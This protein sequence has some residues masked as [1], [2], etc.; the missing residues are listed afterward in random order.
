ME[1]R[2]V[3]LPMVAVVEIVQI[4]AVFF[5]LVAEV[6][7]HKVEEFFGV[8]DR[9]A[10]LG[11]VDLRVSFDDCQSQINLIDCVFAFVPQVNQRPE[12]LLKCTVGQVFD[13]SFGPLAYGSSFQ[14]IHL[15]AENSDRSNFGKHLP[16]VH[17][18]LT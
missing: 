6:F 17:K 3:D 5:E 13:D 7:G 2:A 16:K 1:Q 4:E 11:D 8:H 15:W 14:G 10:Q 18:P 12:I 9:A